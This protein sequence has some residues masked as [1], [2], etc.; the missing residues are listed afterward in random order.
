MCPSGLLVK[1]KEVAKWTDGQGQGHA[2]V[3][4]WP[5]SRTC[6]S[7]PLAKVK[8]VPKWKEGQGQENALGRHAVRNERGETN[9]N[10]CCFS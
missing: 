5:R 4:C 3:D 7:G 2:Q 8:D 6:P 10:T 9:E 1:I